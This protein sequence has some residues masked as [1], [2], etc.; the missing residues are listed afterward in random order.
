MQR[1]RV[2]LYNTLILIMFIAVGCLFSSCTQ[3]TPALMALAVAEKNAETRARTLARI[4]GNALNRAL[5]T[6]DIEKAK[7]LTTE[8]TDLNIQDDAGMAPLHL[9]LIKDQPEMAGLLIEKGA[10][11]NVK[12]NKGFTPLHYA[13]RQGY[14]KTVK[15]LLENGADSEGVDLDSCINADII[16]KN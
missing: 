8:G 10:D 11:V 6:G 13:C 4:D 7:Y 15:L 5:A 9:A 2:L 12:D 16:G 3:R 14:F 1:K